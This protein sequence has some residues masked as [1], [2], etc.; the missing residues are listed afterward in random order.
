M[1][2]EK[3]LVAG[4]CDL[5]NEDN[6]VACR[7]GLISRAVIAMKRVTHFVSEGEH[8]VKVIL[9]VKKDVRVRQA[10]A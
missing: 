3:D 10:I 6:V 4:G 7:N 8:A 5:S 9:M 1:A 2:H